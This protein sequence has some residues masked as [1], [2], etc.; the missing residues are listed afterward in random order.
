VIT[1]SDIKGAWSDQSIV[2]WWCPNGYTYLI[3]S[4]VGP[5]P[6]Y[7]G[8]PIP[9]GANHAEIIIRIAGSFY[10][11]LNLDSHGNPQPFTI[12]P[13]I[14]DQPCIVQGNFSD[15]VYGGDVSFC[16]TVQNNVAG[17]FSHTFDFSLSSFPAVWHAF[18][19]PAEIP[20]ACAA[21]TTE[22]VDLVR[23]DVSTSNNVV[24]SCA[25]ESTVPA[26]IT[27]IRVF[28]T[29]T[30]GSSNVGGW[31]TVNVTVNGSVILGVPEPTV[32]SSP[33]DTGII[34]L[35]ATNIYVEIACGVRSDGADPGGSAAISK[36]I[37]DGIG[38][39]PY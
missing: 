10:A 35:A 30:L 9:S 16:V 1:F 2:H 6:A 25:I 4:C 26:N 29:D 34:S 33:A 23:H 27:R 28:F 37:I 7:A 5:Y 12:P 38:A 32:P 22:W 15:I 8:D 39:D 31:D 21:Y 36:I 14:T 18:N 19:N 17:T 13:G 24:A 20:S 11:A 3:G